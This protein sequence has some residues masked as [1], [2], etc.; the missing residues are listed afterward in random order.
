VL[1]IF[2]PRGGGFSLCSSA[3]QPPAPQGGDGR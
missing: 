3:S 1:S 2:S